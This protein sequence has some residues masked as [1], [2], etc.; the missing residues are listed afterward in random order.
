[1]ALAHTN[2]HR[3]WGAGGTH[4]EHIMRHDL[5]DQIPSTILQS[6]KRHLEVIRDCSAASQQSMPADQSRCSAAGLMP[7]MWQNVFVSIPC[8][9]KRETER[10]MRQ[11]RKRYQYAACRMCPVERATQGMLQRRTW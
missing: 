3:P 9:A 5:L 2:S 6:V 7:G 11:G 4:Q 10:G 1:M 8:L